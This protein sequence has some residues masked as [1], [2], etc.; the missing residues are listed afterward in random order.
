ML[1]Y[2]AERNIAPGDS[3]TVDDVQPFGGPLFVTINDTS[4]VLGGNL[5]SAMRVRL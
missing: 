1:R 3:L 2:L 4:H 5:A